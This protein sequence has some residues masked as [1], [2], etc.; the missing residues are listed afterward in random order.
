MNL[1]LNECTTIATTTGYILFNV[2]YESQ[3]R[4]FKEERRV[5]Y[6]RNWCYELVLLSRI[7]LFAYSLAYCV[8]F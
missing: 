5:C 6:E 7:G 3:I 1:S 8:L 2:S 4:E